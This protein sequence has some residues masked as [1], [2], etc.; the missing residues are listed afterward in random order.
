MLYNS[1]DTNF[2]K[3]T[4]QLIFWL[5][6]ASMVGLFLF[7]LSSETKL[8]QRKISINIDIKDKIN[9]C[10]PAKEKEPDHRKLY[11]F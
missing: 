6:L 5:S 1:S 11:D 10:T 2:S 7:L 4:K 3:L 8:P 9:I